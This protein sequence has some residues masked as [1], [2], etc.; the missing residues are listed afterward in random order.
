MYLAR[1]G[2]GTGASGTKASKEPVLLGVGVPYV[3]TPNSSGSLYPAERGGFLQGQSTIVA[4][5]ENILTELLQMS[6]LTC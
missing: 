4:E 5:F 1:A 2:I 3:E 6:W